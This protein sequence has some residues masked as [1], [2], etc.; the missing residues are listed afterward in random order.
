MITSSLARV[1]MMNNQQVVEVTV[2][3]VT[4]RV[5]IP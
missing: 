5:T 4:T 2:G 3:G 1:A